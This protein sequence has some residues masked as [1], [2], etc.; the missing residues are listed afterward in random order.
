M[1][2]TSYVRGSPPPDG[3]IGEVLTITYPG[4]SHIDYTYYDHG[5][6]VHTV[7]NER[8]KV[9]SYTR[10]PDTHLVTRIDYPQ[11][12]NTPASHEEFTYNNFGQVLTPSS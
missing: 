4:G 12:A 10:D 11:D 8:Q 7:S 2:T 5:H 6:Y 3:G 1:H 9:T